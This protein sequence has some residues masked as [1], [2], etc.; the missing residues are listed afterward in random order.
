VTILCSFFFLRL[1]LLIIKNT[2]FLIVLKKRAKKDQPNGKVL[3]GFA[4]QQ[5]GYEQATH[6]P[7]L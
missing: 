7:H 1:A 3:V 4:H 2:G 5:D 6:D